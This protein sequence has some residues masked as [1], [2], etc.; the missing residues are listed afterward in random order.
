MQP[1]FDV[2]SSLK[3]KEKVQFA[4]QSVVL[5]P[6]L[7]ECVCD[8]GRKASLGGGTIRRDLHSTCFGAALPRRFSNQTQSVSLRVLFLRAY[9][10][11]A[12]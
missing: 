4:T 10:V 7:L 9:S 8:F 3:G 6:H 12:T 2:L 5:C 1:S 11:L